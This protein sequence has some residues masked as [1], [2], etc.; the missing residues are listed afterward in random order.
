MELTNLMVRRKGRA[1]CGLKDML[2]GIAMSGK[3]RILE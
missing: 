3:R 1:R 2:A